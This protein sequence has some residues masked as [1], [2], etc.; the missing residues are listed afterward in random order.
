MKLSGSNTLTGNI[1]LTTNTCTFSAASPTEN[2]YLSGVT[3]DTS[4]QLGTCMKLSGSN[5]LTGNITLT[6][7]T[8]TFSGASPTEI[9]YLCGVAYALSTQLINGVLV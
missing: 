1:T 4:T 8:C 9:G 5:N 3:S 7:N 6:P 2:G